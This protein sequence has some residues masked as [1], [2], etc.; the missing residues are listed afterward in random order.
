MNTTVAFPHITHDRSGRPWIEGANIKV[1]EI[2]RDHIAYSW[3]AE[4]IHRQY[5]HL[6]LA[7]IYAA[8]AYYHAYKSAMDAEIRATLDAANIAA[9][10]ATNSPLARRLRTL[11]RE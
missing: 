1:L 8:L 2:V 7:Q 6:S 4:E 9:R 10:L 3:S 11:T 5:P